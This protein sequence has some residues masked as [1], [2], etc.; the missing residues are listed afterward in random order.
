VNWKRIAAALLVGCA[1]TA[2]AHILQPHFKAGSVPDILSGL[3]L[4]PGKLVAAVFPDRGTASPEFIWRSLLAN[5]V[6]FSGMTY[7]T[8]PRRVF[9]N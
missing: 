6:L 7:L 5:V 9:S 8:L 1:V 2:T 3:L 4:L